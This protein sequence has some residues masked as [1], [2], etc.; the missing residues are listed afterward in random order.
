MGVLQGNE[1]GCKFACMRN[2]WFCS[3]LIGMAASAQAQQVWGLRQCIDTA[4]ARNIEILSSELAVLQNKEDLKAATWAFMPDL[5]VGAGQFLQN[6]RSIDRF[7]NTFTVQSITSNNFQ[8]QTQALLYAG[9][10]LKNQ[11]KASEYAVQASEADRKFAKQTIQFNVANVYLQALQAIEQ[12]TVA[13]QNLANTR[14]SLK[15]VELLYAGGALGEGDLITLQAQEANDEATLINAKNALNTALVNLKLLLR[16]PGDYVLQIDKYKLG[17]VVAEPYNA[18]VSQLVD[19]AMLH[20]YDIVAAKTRV[21]A[22]QSML[23]I[24]K[25]SVLPTVSLG[26][27]VSTVYS[28]NAKN[29]TNTRIAGMQPI[30]VVNGTGQL[31]EAP[32]FAYDLQTINFGKQLSNN[33]GSSVGL[34]V[35][36]PIYS[37]YQNKANVN[38]ASIGV[39]QAQL[40]VDRVS[41]NL[42]NEINTAYVNFTNALARYKANEKAYNLQKTSLELAQKRYQAGQ[43]SEFDMQTT[44]NG[45]LQAE[46]NFIIAKYNY[47]FNRLV[48]DFYAG[49]P[50]EI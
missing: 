17:T 20:R 11:K 14:V 6:G 1:V 2:L 21:Q 29:I 24:N 39:S 22:A 27:N 44:K 23:A 43:I 41:Q 7:T 35:N 28:S 18:T 50:L 42:F 4:L 9:G 16:L 10:R 46:Q 26:A 49:L 45:Y 30:G 31:V 19:T 36:M 13:E 33:L 3:F 5:S 34:N 8:L 15:R 12:V 32:T 38:K 37:K 25:A 40:N 48:L 47:V